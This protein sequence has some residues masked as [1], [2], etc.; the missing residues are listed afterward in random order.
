MHHLL[1]KSVLLGFALAAPAVLAQ[2][3]METK[4]PR[5]M[6]S[7]YHVAPG[8]HVAFLKWMAARDAVDQQ[9]GLPRAQWYA[10]LNGDVWD[11]MAVGPVLTDAQ[12][13][14]EDDAAKAKGLTIGPK[15]SIEFR[16]YI[17]SHTDT[18]TAGPMTVSELVSKVSGP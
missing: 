1:A 17:A 15:A 10:H 14:Q 8:Q 13:K 16:Q 4:E 6:V 7:L 5:A 12:Q 18:L 11:Y 3:G 2:S 9:L